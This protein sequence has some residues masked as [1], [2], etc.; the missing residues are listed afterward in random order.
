MKGKT[1]KASEPLHKKYVDGL[2][3]L[4]EQTEID[5]KDCLTLNA[6][7]I[8]IAKEIQKYEDI[9]ESL[10]RVIEAFEDHEYDI[11]FA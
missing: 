11:D 9:R 3:K 7:P 8:D 6:L 10:K 5:Q 2:Q 1:V 4:V